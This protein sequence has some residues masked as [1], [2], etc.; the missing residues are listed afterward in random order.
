MKELI[1]AKVLAAAVKISKKEMNSRFLSIQE[2]LDNIKII[3]GPEGPIGPK[4]DSGD[5]A[6]P[7]IVEAARTPIGKRGGV[8]SGFH[9]T[10]LLALS[11]RGVVERAG[12]DPKEVGQVVAGCV[13]KPSSRNPRQPVPPLCD[14]CPHARLPRA[15]KDRTIH[16]PERPT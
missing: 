12:I 3:K 5:D 9:A 13:T 16:Y 7:V 4:G 6:K 8:M 10:E 14:H 11:Q 1:Q 2:Q 15:V